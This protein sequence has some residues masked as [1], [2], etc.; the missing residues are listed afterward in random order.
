MAT[1]VFR[2]ID[3]AGVPSRGEVEAD[4][5]QAVTEQLQGPRA[6]RPRHRRQERL[7]GDLAPVRQAGQDL[8]PDGHDPPARHDG[9]LGHDAPAHALRARGPDREQAA[10]RGRRRRCA[11]TSRPASPS[12]T[13]S[14]KH[15]KVFNPLYVAMVA[16]RRDRRRARGVA[17]PGRRP[18]R[19]AD[20]SLR[21]QVK[22][23]MMYPVVVM[24]FAVLV[25][26]RPRRLH[27]PRVRGDLQGVRRRAADDH[28]VHRRDLATSSRTSGTC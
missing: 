21:R 13:R 9:E 7:Q 27:R 11:R 15:P 2:A 25:A 20:E 3:L 6:D 4:N 28:Q 22:S 12:P 18:A 26:D 23:A 14:R 1:F 5:K 16:R 17:D 8:R 19:E 24:A 10:A